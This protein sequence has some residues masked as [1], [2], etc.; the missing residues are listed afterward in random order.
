LIW[1]FSLSLVMSDEVTESDSGLVTDLRQVK[2]LLKQVRELTNAI[3]TLLREDW[4]DL[5]AEHYD[6]HFLTG[7]VTPSPERYGPPRFHSGD[8][9][10]LLL[11]YE[12]RVVEDLYTNQL[13][14]HGWGKATYDD[15]IIYLGYFHLGSRQGRG[16][17][18]L[19]NGDVHYGQF[20]QGW[21]QGL[22]NRT[23][24]EN[25]WY[26]GQWRRG[27]PHGLGR[28]LW[29]NGD[30]YMGSWEHGRTDGFGQFRFANGDVY[31]GEWQ[32]GLRHGHGNQTFVQNKES[33]SGMWHE[34][35]PQ[36]EGVYYFNTG[37]IYRGNFI[38]GVP[39]GL[40]HLWY[41]EHGDSYYGY[42]KDGRKHGQG[43][44][45]MNSVGIAFVGEWSLGERI[46]KQ[47]MLPKD[48]LGLSFGFSFT[49]EYH[50]YIENLPKNKRR[51]LDNTADIHD[52]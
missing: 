8:L 10:H 44:Y 33:Y 5:D 18:Q 45:H 27:L 47:E 19:M 32:A 25:G 3:K 46:S 48:A 36:G 4:T 28:R 40:G 52:S 34:G 2:T 43:E 23:Y 17:V 21:E 41:A 49:P 38:D 51:Q 50:Q 39:N 20:H 16:Y 1:L 11:L 14:P 15:G 35:Q 31:T 29:G 26:A 42:W 37:D 22:G 24:R 12:G 9:A 13:L 7:V 30:A 6:A